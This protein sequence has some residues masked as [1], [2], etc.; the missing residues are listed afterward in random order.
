MSRLFFGQARGA[1]A[2]PGAGPAAEVPAALRLLRGS[3]GG[4]GRAVTVAWQAEPWDVDEP[5]AA[6]RMVEPPADGDAAAGAFP[7]GPEGRAPDPVAIQIEALLAAR[8]EAETVLVA[9]R[10]EAERLQAEAE[11]MAAAARVEA[12]RLRA[13]AAQDR[14]AAASEAAALRGAAGAAL[15]AAEAQVAAAAADARAAALA[16][17]TG[18]MVQLALAVARR[19][20]RQELELRPEAVVT[21]VSEALVRVEGETAVQLY[22]APGDAARLQAAGLQPQLRPGLAPGEFLLRSREGD[23]DGR[24]APQVEAVAEALRAEE[25]EA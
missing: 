21:M 1:V 19:I 17:A 6:G 3:E 18:E 8:A 20:L 10:A 13:E 15:A 2:R 9:A 12:E 14:S 7:G 4:P 22:C 16:A 24:L 5:L 11:A 23:V 25:A